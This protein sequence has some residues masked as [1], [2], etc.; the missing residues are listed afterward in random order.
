MFIARFFVL[1]LVALCTTACAP[2]RGQG[3]APGPLAGP[4]LS[5]LEAR[6]TI[7][8]DLPA[9]DSLASVVRVGRM[10]FVSGQLP[11]GP[12]GEVESPRDLEAQARQA[13]QNLATALRAAGARPADVVQLTVHVV[14]LQ[15]GHPAL[16]RAAA[17]AFF[18]AG[19]PPTGAFL[20]V[21]AL[22]RADALVSVSA[23]AMTPGLALDR[24]VAQQRR[25]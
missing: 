12:S 6:R 17:T 10:V 15:P 21:A 3:G 23:L 22:S 8:V 14:G 16:I 18:P 2:A 13:F 11:L 7:P 1:G 9:A 5:D 20:G 19:N 24:S 4:G 25:P